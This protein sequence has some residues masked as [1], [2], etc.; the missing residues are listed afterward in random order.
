MVALIL[1]SIQL[2]PVTRRA[3][4]DLTHFHSLTYGHLYSFYEHIYGSSRLTAGWPLS[5]CPK[6]FFPADSDP[7][8]FRVT[9]GTCGFTAATIS[10]A[11]I[12][13]GSSGSARGHWFAPSTQTIEAPAARS[14]PRNMINKR[15]GNDFFSGIVAGSRTL[16]LGVSFAS[17][18]LASSYCCVS[19]SKTVS[20]I[21]ARR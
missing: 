12:L 1:P 4:C 13:R 8:P 5:S 15:G 2:R 18:T 9:H 20:W 7:L 19:S 17:C 21:F 3:I 11:R 10:C 14:V 6:D 16:T